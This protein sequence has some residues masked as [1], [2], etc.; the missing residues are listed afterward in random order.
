ME[1]WREGMSERIQVGE[2]KKRLRCKSLK[3]TITTMT[4]D[5]QDASLLRNDFRF[6]FYVLIQQMF[7]SNWIYYS[8]TYYSRLAFIF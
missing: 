6:S 8:L 1:G 5:V 4:L 2:R 7:L 3:M